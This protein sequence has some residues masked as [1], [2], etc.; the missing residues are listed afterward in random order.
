MGDELLRSVATRFNSKLRD[1]DIIARSGGDEFAVVIEGEK[2]LRNINKICQQ[3]QLLFEK[4]FQTK[5]KG[6]GSLQ[7]SN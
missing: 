3:I 6:K 1:N 7:Y 2:A 5:L 4:P